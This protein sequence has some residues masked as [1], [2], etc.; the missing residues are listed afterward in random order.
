VYCVNVTN[1]KLIDSLMQIL[2]QVN[3]LDTKKNLVIEWLRG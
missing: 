3:R 2:Q 1:I